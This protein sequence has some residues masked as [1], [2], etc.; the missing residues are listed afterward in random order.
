MQREA[1]PFAIAV[2]ASVFAATFFST[3]IVD[4]PLFWFDPVRSSWSFGHRPS[5]VAIDWY[6]RTLMSALAWGVAWTAT[7]RLVQKPPSRETLRIAV[8]W[9]AVAFV[10]A[11]GLYAFSLWNRRPLPEPVPSWYEAR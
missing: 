4:V 5:T 3:T 8:A 2:A 1:T 6:G 10:F 9:A 11:A 7:R